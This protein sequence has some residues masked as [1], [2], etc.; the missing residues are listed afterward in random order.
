[1]AILPGRRSNDVLSGALRACPG[2]TRRVKTLAAGAVD[3]GD[4]R[5][6]G[7]GGAEPTPE[8]RWRPGIN[9]VLY[10]LDP[11]HGVTVP[12]NA[13]GVV[14]VKTLATGLHAPA[15]QFQADGLGAGGVLSAGFGSGGVTVSPSQ[16]VYDFLGNQGQS[17]IGGA[18][19]TTLTSGA[20]TGA[21]FAPPV[22]AAA[23][24][25]FVTNAGAITQM[26]SRA[27]AAALRALSTRAAVRGELP[28]SWSVWSSLKHRAESIGHAIEKGLATA[29]IEV[30]DGVVTIALQVGEEICATV[31][32]VIQS[33]WP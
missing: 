28:G 18:K 14:L 15:L 7:L 21:G 6:R 2:H 24:G 30:G 8:A 13:R 5:R 16:H 12:T 22:S 19:P 32:M 25:T 27:T 33:G 1:M 23:A 3:A 29:A 17:P 20:L 31:V 9:N 4:P 26:P 11:V 10:P